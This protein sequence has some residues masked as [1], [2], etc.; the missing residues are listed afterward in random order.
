MALSFFEFSRERM[1][2]NMFADDAFADFKEAYRAYPF[3][4]HVINDLGSD[5]FCAVLGDGGN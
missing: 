3:N 5:F 1:E 4:T 2:Y